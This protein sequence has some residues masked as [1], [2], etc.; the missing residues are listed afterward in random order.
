MKIEHTGPGIDGEASAVSAGL[1]Y[2]SDTEPGIRRRKA[3]RGF[4]Y[5]DRDGARLDARPS[6]DRIRALA[7]PPAWTEVWI[8]PHPDCHIQATGRDARGRK[9][10]RYH[11]RWESCRDNVKFSALAAFARTLPAI[12]KRVD[13]D[14]RRRGLTRERVIATVVWLLDNLLIRVGNVAYARKNRSF[15][16]TT[17]RNRHVNVEG[18]TLRFTFKGKSGKEWRVKVT[19]RRIARL[20]KGMQDMPGQHLFQYFDEN[21]DRRSV[22]SQDVNAYLAE[23][24]GVGFTSKHFRTWAA[25]V[26]ATAELTAIP[27]PESSHGRKI[28]LNAAIDAVA[29]RLGNTRAVCRRCYIHPRVIDVWFEGHLATDLAATARRVRRAPNGLERDEAIVMHWLSI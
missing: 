20:I 13:T 11:E 15:G 26:G 10:Y 25:T 3:G 16:L 6:I 17:L 29:A 28:A 21:G 4:F 7:I 18:S 14:L 27:C 8:A 23:S 2:C 9:Q 24:G 22:T 5:V 12:R 19:D 1:V